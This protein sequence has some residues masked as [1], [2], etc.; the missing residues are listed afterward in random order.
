L[1]L[2]AWYE[3][4]PA[5]SAF[6]NG[7][8]INSGDEL[9]LTVTATSTN[10][11]TAKIENLSTGKVAEHVFESEG[12]ALCQQNAEWIV[13]DYSQNNVNVPFCN[14]GV[15]EFTNAYATTTANQHVTPNGATVIIL[16][17]NGL[18]VTSVEENPGGVTI[19]Y[20]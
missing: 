11:G 9:R 1:I 3:W 2:L 17:K 8:S 13:E 12:T 5:N 20:S 15:V 19:K 14:F 7:F 4:Y 18:D 6:F 16:Q 10:G